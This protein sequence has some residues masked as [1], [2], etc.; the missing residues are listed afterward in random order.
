MLLPLPAEASQDPLFTAG[1]LR[2][3]SQQLAKLA[4]QLGLEADPQAADSRLKQQIAIDREGLAGLAAHPPAGVKKRTLERTQ[5]HWNELLTA[6]AS[7]ARLSLEEP[8][9]LAEQASQ[10]SGAS[11]R[12]GH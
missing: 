9:L 10:S 5:R 12:P 7:S 4:L 1:Q 6:L 2:S 8:G 3:A 11:A